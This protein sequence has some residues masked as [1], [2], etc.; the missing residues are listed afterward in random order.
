MADP[1]IF[2]GLE[3]VAFSAA[4]LGLLVWQL[5]DVRKSIRADKAKAAAEEVARKALGQ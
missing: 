2:K 3:F 5:W 1:G 4:I